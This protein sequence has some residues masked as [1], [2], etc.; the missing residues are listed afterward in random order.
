MEGDIARSTSVTGN[1]LVCPWTYPNFN[2]HIARRHKLF[3][4]HACILPAP[5]EQV[6]KHP[7]MTSEFLQWI[8]NEFIPFGDLVSDVALIVTLPS[9]DEADTF[10]A[11]AKISL[12]VVMRW[13]LWVGTLVSAIPEIS[14]FVGIFSGIVIGATLG[15][16]SQS[17]GENNNGKKVLWSNIAQMGYLS[18]CVQRAG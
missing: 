12:F 7:E 8:F 14:L 18:R 1:R 3:S 4:A 11:P 17:T 10:F 15:P 9:R 2:H 6:V 5:T 16:A 13:L